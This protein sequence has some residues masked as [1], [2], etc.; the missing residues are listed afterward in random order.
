[1]SY[2]LIKSMKVQMA[3]GNYKILQPGAKLP[4][5]WPE[6]VAWLKRG[7]IKVAEAKV[8]A[9]KEKT[10]LPESPSAPATVHATPDDPPAISEDDLRDRS[11]HN[12]TQD[13]FTEDQLL[14]MKKRDLVKLAD[15]LG[16]IADLKSNNLELIHSILRE[17]FRRRQLESEGAAED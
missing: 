4:D 5:N 6:A 7:Y 14:G 8:E 17:Q 10:K 13:G 2:V 11:G 9:V 3:N 15:G 12:S 16:I 1:M